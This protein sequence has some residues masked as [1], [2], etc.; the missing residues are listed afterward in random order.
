MFRHA[1]WIIGPSE[2]CHRRRTDAVAAHVHLL[3]F[4]EWLAVCAVGDDVVSG[5][6]LSLVQLGRFEHSEAD[7]Y[8]HVGRTLEHHGEPVCSLAPM[9]RIYHGSNVLSATT[10]LIHSTTW[11][12]LTGRR[13]GTV[14]ISHLRTMSGWPISCGRVEGK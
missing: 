14:W 2:R 7:V 13:L 5:E 10:G 12:H 8:D 11:T 1:P 3:G 9:L 4:G 6:A